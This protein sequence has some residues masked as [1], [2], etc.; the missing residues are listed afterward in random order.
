VRVT[1]LK[2]LLTCPSQEEEIKVL[3][4]MNYLK[5]LAP[6]GLNDL[7]MLTDV[8]VSSGPYKMSTRRIIYRSVEVTTLFIFFF[9]LITYKPLFF[10]QI[11][12]AM[13]N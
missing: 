3:V 6:S 8:L 1:S 11:S 9:N 2:F 5:S 12:I 4:L 10:N 7:K 13:F